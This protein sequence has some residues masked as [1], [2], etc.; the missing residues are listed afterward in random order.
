MISILKQDPAI[1]VVRLFHHQWAM[2]YGAILL[3]ITW[4]W[5]KTV[6][7]SLYATWSLLFYL[8]SIPLI[9]LLSG[10]AVCLNREPYPLLPSWWSLVCVLVPFCQQIT[11]SAHPPWVMDILGQRGLTQRGFIVTIISCLQPSLLL[12]NTECGL[13][14]QLCISVVH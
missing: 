7:S 9:H 5:Y 10:S 13:W 12:L 11:P 2:C 1:Q 6:L 8:T 4:K 14:A 3:G